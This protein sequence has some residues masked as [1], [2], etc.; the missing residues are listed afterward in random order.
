MR[1]RIGTASLAAM[2]LC[3]PGIA[4]AQDASGLRQTVT[5]ED[6]FAEARV[7]VSPP[8]F[9]E[10]SAP[11]DATA[12][13]QQQADESAGIGVTAAE[14]TTQS[15]RSVFDRG[16]DLDVSDESVLAY[17]GYDSINREAEE[18]RR[19]SL[20]AA[21][22]Q[23]PPVEDEIVL[24]RTAAQTDPFAPVGIRR[25]G[26]V[27]FPELEVGSVYSSNVAATVQNRRDDVGLR[28]APKIALRSDWDRHALAFE[29]QGELVFWDD[30]REQNINNGSAA[31]SGRVDIRSTTTLDWSGGVGWSQT[32][33]SDPEVPDTA[34]SPRTDT[35]Y[36][37][38]ARLTHVMGRIVTQ[39][40]AAATWFKYG[41]LDLAGLGVEDNEDRD[42]VAPSIGLRVGYQ[43]S[44]A[45]QPFVEVTWS[46]RLHD[47][48]VDR[49]G[50]RRD[51]QGVVIRPGITFND[52]SIWSGE[53]AARYEYRDYEDP[54]LAS[55]SALGLDA[56]VSWN[57]TELTTVQFLAA[58]QIEESADLLVSGS[59]NYTAGVLVT[60][61]MLEN[62][63]LEA[64]LSVGYTDYDDFS[65]E[66]GFGATLGAAY[67]IHRE[68][69]LTAGYEFTSSTPEGGETTS[70][71]RISS[72]L[73]FRL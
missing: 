53:V 69:E 13:Q 54:L 62:V 50:L 7:P 64:G 66:T 28:L 45:V 44:D 70:E 34:V 61:Q 31:V 14:T 55:Q 23:L 51:S 8:A 12:Q 35:A 10:R 43:M 63:A 4:I 36:N 48:R 42:Y 30:E 41:N 26:F 9:I 56:N 33:V 71:H 47:L 38:L 2:A 17:S 18:R 32:T 24:R 68:V 21:T 15:S 11:R 5:I 6:P 65:N 37:V 1:G 59:I 52:G 73:R 72:G 67:A 46:P 39:T 27:L 19:L 57:P 29:G 60:H 20:L 58:S 25:G 16:A 49:N 40:T 3:L 22:G